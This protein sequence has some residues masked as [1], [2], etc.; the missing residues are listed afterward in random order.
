METFSVLLALCAGNSPV[1]VNSPHKGQ[2]RGALMFSLIC[3]RIKDWVNNREAGDLR[4][5]H[6]Q[7]DANVMLIK[8][9]CI[10]HYLMTRWQGRTLSMS[11]KWCL[12]PEYHY[13]DD[14][15]DNFL[16]GY[17]RMKIYIISK[18][19]LGVK[20]REFPAMVAMLHVSDVVVVMH[21]Q[22]SAVITWCNVSWYNIQQSNGSS[23]T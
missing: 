15:I 23:R 9:N 6:G 3:A 1:L 7:Y 2:W 12:L 22:P 20:H 18:Y 4:R 14:K 17:K 11:N 16:H 13:K 21:I 5:H 8:G 19:V 10:M